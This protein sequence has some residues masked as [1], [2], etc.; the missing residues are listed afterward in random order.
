M[1]LKPYHEPKK[2]SYA[3][4][5]GLLVAVQNVVETS[6]HVSQQILYFNTRR[7]GWEERKNPMH[8]E[9]L[10]SPA[11]CSP[12]SPAEQGGGN[13]HGAP[14]P[15]TQSAHSVTPLYTS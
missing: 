11:A 13:A 7:A 6:Y 14:R 10:A 8:K 15:D 2:R 12:L 1:T 5:F 4:S 3:G 9:H